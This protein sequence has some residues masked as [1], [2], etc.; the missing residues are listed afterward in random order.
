[1]EGF[2]PFSKSF[3]KKLKTAKSIFFDPVYEGKIDTFVLLKSIVWVFLD[4][5]RSMHIRKSKC[6]ESFA[7]A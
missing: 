1:M 7:N 3:N 5:T 6:Y 4:R 2:L